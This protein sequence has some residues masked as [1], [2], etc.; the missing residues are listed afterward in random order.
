MSGSACRVSSTSF[1]CASLPVSPYL[2]GSATT[3]A[4]LDRSRK[5]LLASSTQ[6]AAGRA[7]EPADLDR[8]AALRVLL[9]KIGA[10]LE[11][12]GVEGDQRLGGDVLRRHAVD[13]ID[14][15]NSFLA[16][17]TPRRETVVGDRA[18]HDRIRPPATQSS[19]CEICL[20]E[21]GVPASLDEVHREARR[22]V[23]PPR[24]P[25]SRRPAN[26][27]PSCAERRRKR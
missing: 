23:W 13:E 12:H 18:D 7:W 15:R 26:R 27:R 10:G 19:I 4:V 3:S 24:R 25:R 21:L 14:D 17:R 16:T 11:A 2:G 1:N 6:P 20:A 22:V 8:R 5:P 9:G